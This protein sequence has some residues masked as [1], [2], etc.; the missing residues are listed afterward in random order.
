MSKKLLYA[1][2]W[3]HVLGGLLLPFIGQFEFAVEFVN[4]NLAGTAAQA[5]AVFWIGVFGPTVAS[6]G[7]L[8]LCLLNNY[9]TQPSVLVWRSLLSAVLLWGLM[10]TSYCLLNGVPQALFTNIPAILLLLVPLLLVH[11]KR[12]AKAVT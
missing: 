2:A 5:G 4:S 10:D 6:W 12:L 3:L 9:F 1:M 8:F 11:P 7:I